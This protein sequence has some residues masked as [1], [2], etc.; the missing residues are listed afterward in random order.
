MTTIPNSTVGLKRVELL[1][2]LGI[3][4]YSTAIT[5]DKL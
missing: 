1:S 2:G 5:K 3:Q 4:N